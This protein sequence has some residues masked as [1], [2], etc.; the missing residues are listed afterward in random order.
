MLGTLVIPPH[1]ILKLLTPF[2]AVAV[3]VLSMRLRTYQEGPLVFMQ[4]MVQILIPVELPQFPVLGVVLVHQ[5][6]V[7]RLVPQEM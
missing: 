6:A 2:G 4:G 1:T 3:A 7:N 5:P